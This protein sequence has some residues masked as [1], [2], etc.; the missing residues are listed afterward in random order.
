MGKPAREA[1]RWGG[2]SDQDR[3]EEW[4]H[5]MLRRGFARLTCGE[6]LDDRRKNLS[7]SLVC[8]RGVT[9]LLARWRWSRV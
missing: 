8:C 4:E 6:H 1:V 2:L 9:G 7:H 5:L 3:K